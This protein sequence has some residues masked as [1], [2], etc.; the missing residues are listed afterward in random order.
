MANR[1]A[2]QDRDE[3]PDDGEDG[4]DDDRPAERFSI[5]G[6][7]REGRSHRI[8]G[9]DDR[10]GQPAGILDADAGEKGAQRHPH[11]AEEQDTAPG[12]QPRQRRPAPI[13][14]DHGVESD[15]AA[16][17]AAQGGRVGIPGHQQALEDWEE[18]SPDADRQQ[19]PEIGAQPIGRGCEGDLPNGH[20]RAPRPRSVPGPIKSAS[21][22]LV[23]VPVPMLAET[24]AG[25]SLGEKLRRRQM[26][27]AQCC[28]SGAAG[29]GRL[30]LW[31]CAAG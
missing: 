7:G 8:R 24:A 16:G 17:L 19:H 29:R 15:E 14:E 5:E 2:T 20:G 3:A 10:R 23:E 22:S 6:G 4:A 21:R 28:P 30:R 31:R 25:G 18:G 11:E 13:G 12:D 26:Q 27:L 1:L 9:R